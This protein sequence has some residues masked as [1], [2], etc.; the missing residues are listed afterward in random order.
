MSHRRDRL[1]GELGSF[2]K[3]Y[4]RPKG[5]GEPNDR[6]YSRDV[7]GRVRRMDP[8]EF[9]EIMRGESDDDDLVDVWAYDDDDDL[10]GAS[11]PDPDLTLLAGEHATGAL[12]DDGFELEAEYDDFEEDDGRSLT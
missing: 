1:A 2:V 5:H 11:D 10:F 6:R 7:Q 3:Q 8:L 9:D 12:D 4:Q